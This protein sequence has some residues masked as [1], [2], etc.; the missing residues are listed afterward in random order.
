MKVAI[1][2]VS[3][4]FICAILMVTQI[5]GAEPLNHRKQEEFNAFQGPSSKVA[6]IAQFI[7]EQ[8][9]HAS[10]KATDLINKS[11]ITAVKFRN[12]ISDFLLLND[13]FQKYPEKLQ[14]F[15]DAFS[16]TINGYE[17][18]PNQERVIPII[19]G[20]PFTFGITAKRGRI[21]SSIA[22]VRAMLE[23]VQVSFT[24]HIKDACA[25]LLNAVSVN[26]SY[27][28]P[29]EEQNLADGN[30]H[31]MD[32]LIYR[33]PELVQ[34]FENPSISSVWNWIKRHID[35]PDGWTVSFRLPQL[36]GDC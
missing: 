8:G 36:K 34:A 32:E 13:D 25:R 28:V 6:A 12:N 17:I 33:Q 29:F 31:Y 18:E 11:V 35:W 14:Q 9:K 19:T 23:D 4:A 10:V 27:D 7:R 16:F 5:G 15:L 24:D 22:I 26:I 21:A 30:V 3:Y 20:K 1:K 2:R